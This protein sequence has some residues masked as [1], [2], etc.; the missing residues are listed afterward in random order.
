MISNRTKYAMLIAMMAGMVTA[1]GGGGS[2]AATPSPPPPPPPPTGGPTQAQIDAA[3]ATAQSNKLCTVLSPFYWEI[4]DKAQKWAGGSVGTGVDATTQLSI[5]SASKWLYAAYVAEKKN[6]VLT[7]T[8][9]TFLTFRSGYVGFGPTIFNCSKTGTVGSCLL[10]SNGVGGTNGDQSAGDVNFFLYNGAHMQVHANMQMGLGA[11]DVV[12][13]GDEIRSTLGVGSASDFY[14]TQPQLAGGVATTAANYA[15][16]LRKILAGNLQISK[17]LDDSEVHTNDTLYPTESHG[18]PIPAPGNPVVSW[19]YSIGH[20]VETD[21][22]APGGVAPGDGAFSSLGALGFYPWI[23]VT[24]TYYGVVARQDTALPAFASAQ[25]GAVVRKA[26]V[27]G[28][29]Q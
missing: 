9:K 1:C 6:G 19:M 8:D 4:G 17:L 11:K 13:L 3:T 22:N 24:K 15:T 10:E 27:T 23:D 28:V 18:T 25:C 29:Q 16:F 12:A 2:T 5:A 21:P 7:S 14:Y 20:W 26:F